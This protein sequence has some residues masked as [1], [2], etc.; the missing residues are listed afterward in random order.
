MSKH[1]SLGDLPIT[2]PRVLMGHRTRHIIYAGPFRESPNSINSWLRED[3]V[4]LA[5]INQYFFLGMS[6]RIEK[7]KKREKK[8]QERVRG[9]YER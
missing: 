4:I 7:E 2:F 5:E 8:E 1:P 9:E 6:N 3:Y